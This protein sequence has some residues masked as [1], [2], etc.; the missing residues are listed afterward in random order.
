MKNNSALTLFEILVSIAILGLVG[1][2]LYFSYTRTQANQA[3]HASAER[4]ADTVSRAKIYSR[5][6]RDQKSWAV[7]NVDDKTYNLLGIDSKGQVIDKRLTVEPLVKIN[8]NFNIVFAIGTGETSQNY[9]II[10][11]NKYGKQIKVEVSKIGLI[12]TTEVKP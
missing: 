6:A 5:E 4:L 11:E 1:F 9:T 12:E 3:L 10:L 8:G 7:K 2:P